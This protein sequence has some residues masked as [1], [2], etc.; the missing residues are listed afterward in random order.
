VLFCVSDN[1]Q[2]FRLAD[3]ETG[4]WLLTAQEEREARL[5][6]RKAR[7][8]AEDRTDKAQAQVNQAQQQIR[9]LM[10]QLRQLGVEPENG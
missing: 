3:M 9:Q 6:E 7:L 1:K 5:E 10:E 8:E 4:E 2:R